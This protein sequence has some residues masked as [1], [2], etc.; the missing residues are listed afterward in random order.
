MERGVW[1]RSGHLAFD[2]PQCACDHVP[3]VVLAEL[4]PGPNKYTP[5][6]PQVP[7]LTR[8]KA[9]PQGVVI[10]KSCNHP[11]TVPTRPHLGWHNP[12]QMLPSP[13]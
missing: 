8:S 3:E 6:H 10:P 1:L 4:L 2:V 5:S 11:N 9:I 13:L 7:P 12:L